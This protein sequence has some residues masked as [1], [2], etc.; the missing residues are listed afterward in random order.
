M[1][2]RLPDFQQ[3][4]PSAIPTPREEAR[5]LLPAPP[6]RPGSA[7]PPAHFLIELSVFIADGRNHFLS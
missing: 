1:P 7:A 5:R 2:E 3:S 4:L 6:A